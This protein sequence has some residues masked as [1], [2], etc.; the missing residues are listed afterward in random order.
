MAEN[1]IH[2]GHLEYA[3]GRKNVIKDLNLKVKKGNIYSFLGPNGAGK[4]TTI[5]LLL[6][7]LIPNKGNI[8]ILG[9]DANDRMS[10]NRRIGVLVESPGL[11]EHLSGYQNMEIQAQLRGVQKQRV[12][13]V[14]EQVGMKDAANAKVKTY[15]TGMKQR[16]GL[17]IAML[18]KPE[19]LILDEPTNGLD[20][21]GIR[22]IRNLLID[23]NKELGITIFLSTHL[24][25]EAEK[26]SHQIGIIQRGNLVF[27][28]SRS[29]LQKVRF[30]A[31]KAKVNTNDNQKAREILEN[32]NYI[33]EEH[34][35]GF[36]LVECEDQKQLSGIS[37]L[38]LDND[39]DVYHSSLYEADLE[40]M[41]L[42]LIKE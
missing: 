22:E 35:E 20:P 4:S 42:N 21:Q 14:I 33:P 13:E 29:E 19:L 23:L 8:H 25:S 27:E 2:V 24:L 6:G 17:G 11:Y 36:L 9:F 28:G 7:L 5:K 1:A 16:I 41:F 34:P 12:D 3:Y 39:L 30:S 40:E 38:L 18:Q 32:N 15:S 10:I 37:R 26:V 31:A